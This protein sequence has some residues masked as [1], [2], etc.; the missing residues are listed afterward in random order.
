MTGV[1]PT[2]RVFPGEIVL[3]FD[4]LEAAIADCEIRDGIR[5]N[6]ASFLRELPLDV[7]S[8]FESDVEDII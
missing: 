5:A 4:A 3:W 7:E 6:L 8:I 2:V 1:C